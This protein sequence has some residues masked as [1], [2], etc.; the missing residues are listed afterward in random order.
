MDDSK[1]SAEELVASLCLDPGFV[2]VP[3]DRYEELIRA[4]T[5]RDVLEATICG[6]NRY[7]VGQVMDAIKAARWRIPGYIHEKRGEDN[8]EQNHSDGAPDTRPGATS[9][10]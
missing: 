8:A 7:T 3:Q 9:D 4:E 6:E 10:R 5:E 2:L 1:K